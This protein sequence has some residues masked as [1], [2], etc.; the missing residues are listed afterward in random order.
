MKHLPQDSPAQLCNAIFEHVH[1]QAQPL[2]DRRLLYQ[3]FE[4]LL[5]HNI[6]SLKT[7]GPN[8]VQ[9]VIAAIDGERDPRNLMV[10]FGILPRFIKEFPLGSLVEE[11]FDVIA[12][13]FPVDYSSVI[14]HCFGYR[15]IN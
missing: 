13:Y 9:G 3:I 8:F 15:Y 6:A 5:H 1:C 10:L 7:I 2:E 11:M 12:C 14:T 4:T